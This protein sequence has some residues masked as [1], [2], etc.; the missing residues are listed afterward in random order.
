MRNVHSNPAMQTTR[1]EGRPTPEISFATQREGYESDT[2]QRGKGQIPGSAQMV[3]FDLED[4]SSDSQ[5][6]ASESKKKQ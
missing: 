4:V 1:K 5:D 3:Q 2:K 6:G